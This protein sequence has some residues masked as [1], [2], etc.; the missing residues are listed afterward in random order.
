MF[1]V[2]LIAIAL[3]FAYVLAGRALR[4]LSMRV[5]VM[6]RFDIGFQRDDGPIAR[7]IGRLARGR[8]S[9]LVAIAPGLVAMLVATGLVVAGDRGPKWLALVYAALALV[10]ALGASSRH[11]GPLDWLTVAGLRATEYLFIVV[12]GV[13]GGVPLW[14]IYL[15]LYALVLYHYDIV[16]RIEKTATPMRGEAL[17]RGWDVR[18]IILGTATTLGWATPT[19]A[20]M[21]GVI[22]VVFVVGALT[23]W[24]QTSR[25]ATSATVP[26]AAALSK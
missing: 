22:V 3:A 1:I 24:R 4:A 2:L 19:Y 21:A 18:V 15:L 8:V 13:L 20:V 12:A 16:G 23:G 7:T 5:V 14:L 11:D 17:L 25:P 26:A 6:P 10:A 9:P